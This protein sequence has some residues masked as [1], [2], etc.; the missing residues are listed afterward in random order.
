MVTRTGVPCCSALHAQVRALHLGGPEQVLGRAVGGH[1]AGLEN[2]AAASRIQRQERVLLDEK[3]GRAAL[4]VGDE[5][6]VVVADRVIARLRALG[7]DVLLFS[8]SHILRVL[9]ARWLGLEPAGGGYFYLGT[10]TLSILGYEHNM[11]EPVVR[12]LMARDGV[13]E[14]TIRLLLA[15]INR[16]RPKPAE[17]RVA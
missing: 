14:A 1:F 15:E 9:A 17:R 13:D 3:H 7:T 16:R 8:S 5:A 11:S 10:A 12:L 2:V 4:A 6:Q